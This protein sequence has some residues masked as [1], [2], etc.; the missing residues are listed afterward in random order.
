MRKQA[1]LLVIISTI[2]S[3]GSLA[4]SPGWLVNKTD[5][6]GLSDLKATKLYVA[7]INNDDYPDIIA[8]NDAAYYNMTPITIM[9][10]TKDSATGK[11][12]F[13]DITDNSGVNKNPVADTTG[14]RT[15]MIALA[16]VNNDGFIDMVT[17]IY[18]GKKEKYVD[19]GDRCEILLGDGT[20][21]FNLYPY[22]SIHNLGFINATGMSFLDYDKDGN[23]DLFIAKW[24]ADS[25]ATPVLVP[26]GTL[27]KGNGDGTFNDVSTNA[28]LSAHR[29]PMMGCSVTD[30]NNDGWPDILTNSYFY[31]GGQ[32]WKNNK[33]STF[34]NV[35][36]TVGYNALATMG[37]N[38]KPMYLKSVVPGDFDNDQDIDL[39]FVLVHGGN[40][41]GEGRT[42]ILTN[43]GAS[44]N[45]T[46]GWEPNRL[47]WD[48]PKS[49]HHGDMDASWFDMDNDGLDDLVMTQCGFQPLNDRIYFF[50]QNASKYYDDASSELGM[51]TSADY[52]STL[53]VEVLDYD[54]D[55]DEDVLFS[56]N[57]ELNRVV[58]LENEQGQT[59]NWVSVKLI[60][61]GWVNKSAIGTKIKLYSG[62]LTKTKEIYA[63]RGNFGGQQSFITNFGLGGRTVIDS[64]QV[65]WP[66]AK[67]TIT[68]AIAPPINKVLNINQFGYKTGIQ[69]D[70]AP[71]STIRIYPNPAQSFILMNVP[72][73]SVDLLSSKI[74]LLSLSGQ[75][76]KNI[77]VKAS[78]H[79]ALYIDVNSLTDGIYI[80]KLTTPD[81]KS[82]Y[83]KFERE[84]TVLAGC[85]HPIFPRRSVEFPKT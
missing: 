57:N 78:S 14:R 50:K 18:Y 83:G 1:L 36:S 23:I 43:N 85:G 84:R 42:S 39:V 29:D 33:N 11:R 56:K 15:H 48:L 44:G 61:P 65:I 26:Y 62:A 58:F 7:D 77:D 79:H 20:G 63:G 41:A 12:V 60:P 80:V 37:D 72:D 82:F 70:N 64:I 28:G 10:N 67:G 24:Y 2:L 66:D 35:A 6:A 5:D 16:D 45:Y 38:G 3:F 71:S 49:S 69:Q 30:W 32:L 59:S 4:Q 19:N 73:N 74:E 51:V 47:K 52:K 17:C 8:L 25:T 34:T 55:G 27:L 40:D 76:V 68:S 31:S 13:K 46:L 81:G 21:K 54:L 75:L 22:T 53:S 9:L